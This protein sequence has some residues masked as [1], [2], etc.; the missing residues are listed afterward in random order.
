MNF[1]NYFYLGKVIRTHGIKGD[2]MIYLD[3]DHPDSYKK[4]GIIYLRLNE[5]LRPFNIQQISIKENIARVHLQDIDDMNAALELVQQE[6]YL[7]L[8]KL[9]K[10]KEGQFFTHDLLQ[11]TAFDKMHGEIGLVS[12]ILEMPMQVIAKI[13]LP[14]KKEALIPLNSTFIEQ[15]DKTEKKIFFNLP[16]GLLDIYL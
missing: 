2:L 8:E 1:E 3:A 15:V 12:E 9:P 4:L 16:D 13:I 11:F 5:D 14:N 6:A 7:P 10:L